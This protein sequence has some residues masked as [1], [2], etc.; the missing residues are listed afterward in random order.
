MVSYPSKRS[1]AQPPLP[2]TTV[3]G[4]TGS[5]TGHSHPGST[6]GFLSSPDTIPHSAGR[7]PRPVSSSAA[8]EVSC[9]GPQRVCR[10]VP[11]LHA[12]SWSSQWSHDL[13]TGWVPAIDL[14]LGAHSSTLEHKEAFNNVRRGYGSLIM[15]A[16]VSQ[17]GHG[18]FLPRCLFSQS[19]REPQNA[20]SPIRCL[21]S[22]GA[23]GM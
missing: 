18:P 20:P 4:V 2:A 1:W 22:C 9:E 14:W 23:T 6:L 15:D 13:P 7:P 3:T 17:Q 16:P 19:L 8:K 11:L 12:P 10:E 5:T 21:G